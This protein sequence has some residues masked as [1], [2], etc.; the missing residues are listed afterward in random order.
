MHTITKGINFVIESMGDHKSPANIFQVVCMHAHMS[1]CF[2]S[3]SLATHKHTNLH[4][5]HCLQ[6][7]TT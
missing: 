1:V 7:T 3:N 2:I 5:A 4:G 6:M